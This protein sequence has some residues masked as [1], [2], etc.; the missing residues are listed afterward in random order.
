[1]FLTLEGTN[2]VTWM[3]TGLQDIHLPIVPE[4]GNC[5]CTLAGAAMKGC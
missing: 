1:M 2:I 3:R 5:V 4:T